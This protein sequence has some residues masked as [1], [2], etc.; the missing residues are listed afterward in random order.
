MSSPEAI[1]YNPGAVPARRRMQTRLAIGVARLLAMRSPHQI[2]TVL[3]VL[4]RGSRP[5]TIEEAS[6][7]RQNVVAVSLRC[8]G[9]EGC[10]PRSLAVVLLCRARGSWATWCVGARRFE[11][12]TAHAWIEAEGEPVGEEYPPDYFRTLL[13][14]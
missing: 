9:P 4:R 11:P 8:A 1:Y 7:A 3:G 6:A 12:F 5:A 10:L 14:V 13:S 2:R